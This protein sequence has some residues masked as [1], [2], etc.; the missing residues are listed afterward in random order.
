M[1]KNHIFSGLI[2][3]SLA[4]L[5][6]TAC[7]K[8]KATTTKEN[9]TTVAPEPDPTPEAEKTSSYYCKKDIGVIALEVRQKEGKLDYVSILPYKNYVMTYP[10]FLKPVVENGGI[11]KVKLSTYISEAT[12]LSSYFAQTINLTSDGLE[13]P[14]SLSMDEN[15]NPYGETLLMKK[16]SGKLCIYT[17]KASITIDQ[18][19]NISSSDFVST[20]SSYSVMGENITYSNGCYTYK[21]DHE[22]KYSINMDPKNAYVELIAYSPYLKKNIVLNKYTMD[23]TAAEPTAKIYYNVISMLSG[24]FSE[25]QGSSLFT[26][27]KL[28]EMGCSKATL[29]DVG[30]IIKCEMSS[31]MGP[32]TDEVAFEYSQDGKL[33]SVIFEDSSETYKYAYTYDDKGRVATFEKGKAY[34]D[35]EHK[36]EWISTSQDYTK[37][38]FKEY[39]SFGYKQLVD[40]DAF[41]NGG[42]ESKNRCIYTYENNKSM[43]SKKVQEFVT[44]KYVDIKDITYEYDSNY[45]V[46]ELKCDSWY[47]DG[48][49]D[50]SESYIDKFEYNTKNELTKS[51]HYDYAYDVDLDDYVDY[52]SS[53]T[54]YESNK[55][56]K[57]LYFYKETTTYYDC[58]DNNTAY[59]EEII[60][61]KYKDEAML[62]LVESSDTTTDLENNKTA[63]SKTIVTYNNDEYV[64][65][66]VESTKDYDSTSETIIEAITNT[67][68][69]ETKKIVKSEDENSSETS[70]TYY[71]EKGNASTLETIRSSEKEKTEL[72]YDDN[73]NIAKLENYTY[74]NSTIGY[75]IGYSPDPS[76]FVPGTMYFKDGNIMSY[77]GIIMYTYDSSYKLTQTTEIKYADSGTNMT[78]YMIVT[79]YTN[80]IATAKN[81]MYYYINKDHRIEKTV[82]TA[83][84]D[85]DTISE[86]NITIYYDDATSTI[87]ETSHKQ[88]VTDPNNHYE[89]TKTTYKADGTKDKEYTWNDTTKSWDEKTLSV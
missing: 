60:L 87:Q 30:N 39:S 25:Y 23:I 70:I 5:A 48:D 32:G 88:L 43:A 41:N 7:G 42:F 50:Y 34:D 82:Q 65:T 54:T 24:G 74:I 1:K 77:T 19:G 84:L 31:S 40:I 9:T 78:E 20:P 36:G 27:G 46:K 38:E 28:F 35:G 80:E 89:G 12:G 64:T 73:N 15:V 3:V 67:Y 26:D 83:Y 72:T 21:Y 52:I 57:N 18:N 85:E 45:N 86:E 11:T 17:S 62:Y 10:I 44:D 37:Y 13:I 69:S 58:D 4:A 79:S 66:V 76:S 6:F 8:K 16:D 63:Y 53:I 61:S 14:T 59:S 56:D 68:D 47:T 49:Q 71:N 81:E 2:M 22:S 33:V 29:N 51:T 55:D 75:L